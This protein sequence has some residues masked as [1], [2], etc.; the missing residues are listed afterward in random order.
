[1]TGVTMGDRNGPMNRQQQL[2]LRLATM[3]MMVGLVALFGWMFTEA[4]PLMFIGYGCL[5]L[6]LV[7]A[8]FVPF[9]LLR[10]FSATPNVR[11][12]VMISVLA[13][14]NLPVTFFSAIQGIRQVTRYRVML[15]NEAPTPWLEVQLTSTDLVDRAATVSAAGE[16]VRDLWFEKD[17][18][19]ELHYV[20]DDKPQSLVIDGYV[21]KN[22]GGLTTVVRGADGKVRVLEN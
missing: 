18:H 20:H 19:L 10:G 7:I 2:A 21:T 16:D 14:M 4:Q 9:L 13:L 6:G 17:G 12:T 5:V 1:M 8:M 3:P 15:R 22:Q 11:N